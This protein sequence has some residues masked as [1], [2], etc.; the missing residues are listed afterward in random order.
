MKQ[1]G[2][3][4]IGT[5]WCGGIR[6]QTCAANPLVKSLHLAE[7]RPERLAE[8]AKATGARTAVTDYRELLDIAEIEA[9]YISATPET[10][11]YPMARD[12]LAAGKHVFLEKPIALE[13]SEADELIALARE[14]KLKFTIGYSQRFNP[15]VRLRPEVDSR[16]HHRP[17]GE[18]AGEPPHHAQPRQEDQRPH[19]AV[20]GRD[21]SDPRPGLRAVVPGAGQAG[22]RLLADQFRHDARDQRRADSRHPVDHRDHGQRRV[23][24]DRRA[25]GRCRRAIRISRPPGSSSSAPRARSWST[26]AIATSC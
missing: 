7:I 2:V 22:A 1:I 13:L 15:E 19:Q 26:T 10:T 21:G 11:H 4:I 17:A 16:R 12:C 18:R 9:V 8:V 24:R 5:G 6:A 25:A 23:V 14:R 3:G 20:A